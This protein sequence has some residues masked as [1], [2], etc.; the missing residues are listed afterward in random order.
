[1]QQVRD[2]VAFPEIAPMLEGDEEA[3]ETLGVLKIKSD[4]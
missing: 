3:I 2:Y 1:M 4:L